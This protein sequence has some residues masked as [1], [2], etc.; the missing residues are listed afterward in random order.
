MPSTIT[1][2]DRK[3]PHIHIEFFVTDPSGI[4]RS[5]DGIAD[6][7]APRTEFNDR[8]LTYAGFTPLPERNVHIKPGL[9]TQKH[10]RLVLP[11]IEICDQTIKNLEV[12]VSHLDKSWGIAALIGL[13]F[14]RRFRITIDYDAGQI[15]TEPL[16]LK[17]K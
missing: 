2:F 17:T 16:M 7:G 12:M 10:S 6:T 11:S 1:T 3:L 14:F 9:E 8:F 13:D 5:F 15:V 4:R